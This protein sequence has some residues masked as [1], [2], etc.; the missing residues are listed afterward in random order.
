MGRPTGRSGLSA[1]VGWDE[2]VEFGRDAGLGLGG[3]MSAPKYRPAGMFRPAGARDT[4]SSCM[5]N[6]PAVA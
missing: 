2:H 1:L 6:Q 4:R 3:G 5:R